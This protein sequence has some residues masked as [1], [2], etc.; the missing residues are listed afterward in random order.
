MVIDSLEP[1]VGPQCNVRIAESSLANCG[2]V[3]VTTQ[4][5]F[6]PAN[7][8]FQSPLATVTTDAG[9]LSALFTVECINNIGGGPPAPFT[10]LLDDAF[11]GIGL[12]PVELQ[13]FSVE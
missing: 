12:T 2:N 13:G 3:T 1:A 6:F 7:V 11:F 5:P 9:T 4:T 10:L 8:F